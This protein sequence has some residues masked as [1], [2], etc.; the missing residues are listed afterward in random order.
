LLF[1][2]KLWGFGGET[3]IVRG[4]ARRRCD[5]TRILRRKPLDL[6]RVAFIWFHILRP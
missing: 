6:E 1:L 5:E 2:Q 4:E 3:P